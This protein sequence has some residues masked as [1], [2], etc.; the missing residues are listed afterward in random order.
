MAGIARTS[1]LVRVCRTCWP[2]DARRRTSQPGTHEPFDVPGRR[3]AMD[4]TRRVRKS[5][6][7][8]FGGLRKIERLGRRERKE[9]DDGVY[10]RDGRVRSW[11]A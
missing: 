8:W 7:N 5:E 1:P 11:R 10:P 9:V 3:K 4:S 6:R 2:R